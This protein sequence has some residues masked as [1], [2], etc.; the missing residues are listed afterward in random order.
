MDQIKEA[1]RK[2]KEDMDSLKSEISSLNS[3]ISNLR[4][5]LNSLVVPK[6][7]LNEVPNTNSNRQ[8]N[9]QEIPTHNPSIP[10][11]N[12]L[13]RPLK[14]QNIPI[15]TGNEGVPTDRQT[16]QQ[17]DRQTQNMPIFRQNSPSQ[18]FPNSNPPIQKTSPGNMDNALEILN[19][20]DSLKREIRLK[21]KDLTDQEFLVF[22]TL[23]QLDEELGFS[24]Y[25]TLSLK[26]GLSESSIRDY[27]GKLIKKEIPVEKIKINNKAIKLSI[28]PNLKKVASLNTIFQL[29]GL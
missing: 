10:T 1:F 13:F 8:T 11:N 23:Y 24:D 14:G 15:S 3:E 28:S 20:L 26:L 16:N 27:V 19:S 22:S 7:T 17:T 25:K 18:P 6:N 2:V 5:I 12:S 21:F 4:D 29:R 9:R